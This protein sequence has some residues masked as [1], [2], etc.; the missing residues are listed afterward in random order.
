MGL[1]LFHVQ[2]AKYLP[3]PNN[4]HPSAFA[5]RFERLPQSRHLSLR[6][7]HHDVL[8]AFRD[9]K[10]G[11]GPGSDGGSSITTTTTTTSSSRVLPSV[12]PTPVAP[13][14]NGRR[15]PPLLGMGGGMGM[16]MAAIAC[17]APID[18]GR[19]EE[20]ASGTATAQWGGPSCLLL[21]PPPRLPGADGA[22]VSARPGAGV[23]PAVADVGGGDKPFSS[24]LR[25]WAA[26]VPSG[27]GEGGSPTGVSSSGSGGGSGSGLSGGDPDTQERGGQGP[28]LAATSAAAWAATG[29]NGD[30]DGDGGASDCAPFTLPLGSPSSLSAVAEGWEGVGVLAGGLRPTP[31]VDEEILQ[32]VFAEEEEE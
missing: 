26:A 6:P 8:Q 29:G 2:P 17:G 24:S 25:A 3:P 32:A 13:A 28:L 10:G 14:D 4:A 19:M 5:F 27:G 23:A 7:G 21:F 12:P 1:F 11:A 9:N 15:P 18:A 31:L 30:G 20:A 22:I 16:G